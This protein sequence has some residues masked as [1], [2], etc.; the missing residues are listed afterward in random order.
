M[1]ERDA[2]GK[3][4]RLRGGAGGAPSVGGAMGLHW[5][6]ILIILPLGVLT[7]FTLGIASVTTMAVALFAI[8]IFAVYAAQDVIPWWYVLYGVGAE[9]LLVWAL[10][11][12][13]KKLM[14][15]NERVVGISLHGW[16]KSRREA[17]QSGK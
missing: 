11:P 2:N 16:L 4:I 5:Q 9:I 7:F 17:K 3:L 15:G 1:P 6:S 13:L 14:E 12:N 10:R 8:I